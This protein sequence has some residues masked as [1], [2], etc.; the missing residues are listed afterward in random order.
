MAAT[1]TAIQGKKRG[2]KP[3]P[4]DGRADG[5]I[6]IPCTAEYEAFFRRLARRLR[7]TR[8]GAFDRIV[9]EWVADPAHGFDEPP[10]PRVGED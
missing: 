6:V 7:T 1:R 9:V 10:P 8:A 3:K 4:A 5:R 2:P